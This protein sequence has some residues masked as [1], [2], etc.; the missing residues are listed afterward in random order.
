MLIVG[1]F[2]FPN[3]L[4]NSNVHLPGDKH[5]VVCP[6]DGVLLISKNRW[7]INTGNSMDEFQMFFAKLKNPHKKATQWWVYLY[8]IWKMQTREKK[9]K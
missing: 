1:L 7:A 8:D 2:I 3:G 4:N 6:Y 5:T 9:I